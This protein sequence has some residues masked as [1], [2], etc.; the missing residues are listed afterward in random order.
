M[1]VFATERSV[2]SVFSR[3]NHTTKILEMDFAARFINKGPMLKHM[4][5]SLVVQRVFIVLLG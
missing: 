2:E 1:A 5:F 3:R 4:G